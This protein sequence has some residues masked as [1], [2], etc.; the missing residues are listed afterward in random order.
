[1][2]IFRRFL[3]ILLVLSVL[4]ATTVLANG[5]D[6][7]SKSRSTRPDSHAPL[8]V[9]GDH[10]HGQSEWMLSYR[11]MA[12][13][14]EGLRDGTASITPEEIDGFSVIPVNMGMQ[15][16]MVGLMFAPH[17]SITLMVMTS[18]RDNYME[19]EA[20]KVTVGEGMTSTDVDGDHVHIAG[21]HGR[22]GSRQGESPHASHRHPIGAHEM[23]SRGLGDLRLS[24]LIPLLRTRNAVFL[25]NTGLSIPT[26]SITAE[27]VNGI[28][29]YPM[30]LGSGSFEL[31]PGVTFT[32][33]LGSWSF[34][35]QTQVTLPL[36]ENVRGYRLGSASLSTIWGGRRVN[37]WL[38]LSARAL[39]ESWGN[40]AG[41]DRALDPTMAPTMDPRLRGG[42]RGSLLLGCN[43]IFP[44]RL[45]GLLAGQRFAVEARL[46][47]YQHLDGPQ[48]ELGWGVVAGWQ[49]AFR[50][51]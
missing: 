4:T 44:N 7:G 37:D 47:V 33:M 5:G 18:Y 23:E 15:M 20:G 43:L 17:D 50:F 51:W 30:Q 25:L 19:M 40:I 14:M 45:G 22:E 34:G 28:L 38:S 8:G 9:M 3:V 31:T 10:A 27:G 36:N 6:T 29:P 49:Y 46:P 26:G 2:K 13:G 16:H 12:M 11:F 41:S 42:G 24:A 21:S 48:L 1:M 32:T 39:F 35:G